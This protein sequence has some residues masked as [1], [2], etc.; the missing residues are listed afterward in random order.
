MSS[1]AAADIM[2][3]THSALRTHG[4]AGLTMQDIADEAGL[5]TAALHY[6][7]DCKHDLLVAFL[8]RLFEQFEARIAELDG[9]DA[10]ER[11]LSL[12]ETVLLPPTDD[13]PHEF[14]TALLEIEAQAPYDDA[15]RARLE[16]FDETFT[17]RVRSILETGVEEGTFA[18]DV[19]PDEVA[20]FVVTYVRGA[21]T[22]NVAVGTPL[23]DSL[24][25]F[26]DYVEGT[27]LADDGG[28]GE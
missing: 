25:A 28:A 22:Q 5:S 11:L 9:D 26:R 18:A 3:G 4:Y 17:A 21:R 10:A 20:S 2:D 6:H 24:A 7:F 15:F 8:D 23:D 19:D 14:R 16:R 12:V 27:L 13:D 1:D